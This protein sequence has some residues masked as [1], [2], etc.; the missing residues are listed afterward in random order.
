MALRILPQKG[1]GRTLSQHY[2]L[3]PSASCM[4]GTGLGLLGA[5]VHPCQTSQSPRPQASVAR[6][7]SA[8][9]L[10]ALDS[11]WPDLTPPVSAM[12]GSSPQEGLTKG[13]KGSG[14]TVLFCCYLKP[15]ASCMWSLHHGSCLG[16]VVFPLG[17]SAVMPLLSP[18][19]VCYGRTAWADAMNSD[20][21]LLAHSVL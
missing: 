16:K 4:P 17:R 8:A 10:S 5:T 20:S 11:S 15:P 1:H 14:L 12:P 21:S 2:P 3:L 18:E 9:D 6:I 13:K 19:Q 7:R